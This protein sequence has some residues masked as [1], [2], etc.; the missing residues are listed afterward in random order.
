MA[1]R[2]YDLVFLKHLFFKQFHKG[3]QVYDERF[4]FVFNSYYES[5]GKRVVRANRGN[6]SRPTVDEI[7]KYRKHVD[8]AMEAFLAVAPSK[9]VETLLELGLQ[10]EQQHQEL[11]ITDIK[12]ILGHNPLLPEYAPEHHFQLKEEQG[13]A[14]F[15]KV[16][17]G[18]HKIGHQEE[19]FCYDNELGVHEVLINEFEIRNQLV[20]NKEYLEFIEAGVYQTFEYWHAEAWDWIQKNDVT[21]PLYWHKID[22]IWHYYTLEG[23]KTIELDLPVTHIS[24]YE[25]AAFAAWK[26]M[27]LPIEFEWE[28]ASTLFKWGQCWECT[29]SAYLPY[30][31][32]SKAEGAIGEYNGKFMVNQKV[33]R[34]ASIVTSPIHARHT[35]RNFFHAPLR[36]QFT[37]I[38]LVKN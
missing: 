31:K 37:G 29:E 15:I 23:L 26:G 8:Q 34:G 36:W 1:F 18:I 3:Y 14:E 11:L 27:R 24:Y 28:V 12:Y 20:T 16:E 2:T 9:E 32:F 35:Y 21:A 17:K 25:A 5:V 30:P 38:R 33:L 19:S 6:L 13:T 10:H 7:Y 22:G 4:G